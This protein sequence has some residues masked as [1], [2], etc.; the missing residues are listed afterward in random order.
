[1]RIGFTLFGVPV[2]IIDTS[3][4]D[5]CFTDELAEDG[6]IPLLWLDRIAI[7]L[8]PNCG[9]VPE[10]VNICCNACLRENERIIQER[11]GKGGH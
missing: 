1:V 9:K 7:D 4:S 8:C 2:T 6:Y 5:E 11:E 10:A 3:V